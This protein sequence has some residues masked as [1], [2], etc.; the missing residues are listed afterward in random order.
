M[1]VPILYRG[2]SDKYGIRK[3]HELYNPNINGG[4]SSSNVLLT[5]LQNSGN[6]QEIFTK[7]LYDL[8]GLH[9]YP[10]YGKT[11]FL[12][13]SENKQVAMHYG[14]QGRNWEYHHKNCEWDF[15]IL[16]LNLSGLST[17]NTFKIFEGIYQIEYESALVEFNGEGRALLIDSMAYL[18]KIKKMGVDIKPQVF[19][20]LKEDREWLLL[21]INQFNNE[22]SSKVSIEIISD[23]EYFNII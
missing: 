3:I 6:G 20:N 13:F 4:Y 10:G 5:N 1:N 12:S 23:I 2:D 16:T 11:H 7:K 17:C 22:F 9:I 19:N 15:F 18:Q 21:P 14:S 8:A